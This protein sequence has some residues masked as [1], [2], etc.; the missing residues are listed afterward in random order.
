MLGKPGCR[1]LISGLTQR[2]ILGGKTLSCGLSD[3]R[4]FGMAMNTGGWSALATSTAWAKK[5]IAR[6]F[7]EKMFF[8]T[9]GW[10]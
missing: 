8:E 10:G 4:V 1:Y 3:L 2:S 7:S 9:L 5:R 6:R